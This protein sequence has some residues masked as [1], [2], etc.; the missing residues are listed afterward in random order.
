LA[1]ALA[2]PWVCVFHSRSGGHARAHF[3]TKE[4]A[5]QFAERHARSFIPAAAPLTWTDIDDSCV[6]TVQLG[7]YVVSRIDEPERGPHA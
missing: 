5:K 6:L 2:K 7:N 3:A 1:K 4:Q